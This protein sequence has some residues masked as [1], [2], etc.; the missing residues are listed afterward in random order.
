VCRARFDPAS[1]IL[2]SIITSRG[3]CDRLAA[4]GYVAMRRRSSIASSPV[5]R[6][7]IRRWGSRGRENS[8]PIPIGRRCLRE[9]PGPPSD[10]VK[11][12]R[13]RSGSSAFASAAVI[14]IRGC[15]Q[16]VGLSAA[17]R[18]LR[19]A[20]VRSP[21]TS[22]TVPTQLPFRRKGR[23]HSA[24]RVET[25]KASV[26]TSRSTSYPGAQHGFHC[27]ERASYDKASADIAWPRS[28]AFFAKHLKK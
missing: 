12:C 25:I 2:A 26:P 27:D 17:D 24:H 13:P 14:C 19:G 8:S 15:D 20:V 7:A 11:K 3:L 28:M 22:P 4:E 23:G 9:H 5:S 10:A 6:Q 1:E 18:L 16:T 21:T